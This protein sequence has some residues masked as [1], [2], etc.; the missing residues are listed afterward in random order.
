MKTLNKLFVSLSIEGQ[1]YEVG[2][3]VLS[4]S[5]GEW[6]LAPAYGL[7][8][9]FSSNGFHSTMVAGESQNPGKKHLLKLAN[10]F[11]VKDGE[12][13]I[14]EVISAIAEWSNTAK[15]Y[16]IN[17]ETIKDIQLPLNSIEKSKR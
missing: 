11:G 4:N 8:F 13:I 5:N 9:S 1:K 3:L 7:T 12:V 10:H 16:D 14:D 17:S 6:Q 15:K 2:G